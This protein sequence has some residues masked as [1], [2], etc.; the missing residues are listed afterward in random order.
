M[1]THSS[2][3][4]PGRIKGN[5]IVLTNFRG[6]ARKSFSFWCLPVSI[7]HPPLRFATLIAPSCNPISG[8]VRGIS[9]DCLGKV[10]QSIVGPLPRSKVK[11]RQTAEKI[12]VG[13]EI[14]GRLAPRT[15]DFGLL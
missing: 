11:R 3:R 1:A 8:R 10:P 7:C 9:V 4:N 13:V 14:G 12:V 2:E 5:W 15:L 6:F